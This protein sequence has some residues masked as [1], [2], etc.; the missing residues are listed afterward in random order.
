[1]TTPSI[2]VYDDF[3]SKYD[4]SFHTEEYTDT[5]G[6]YYDDEGLYYYSDD[7]IIENEDFYDF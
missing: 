7:E 1:M 5:N 3:V 6:N 4:I 2:N